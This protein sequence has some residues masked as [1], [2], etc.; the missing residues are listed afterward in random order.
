MFCPWPALAGLSPVRKYNDEPSSGIQH[1]RR[2]C[3]GRQE[4]KH[5][6]GTTRLSS[7]VVA[8]LQNL[9]HHLDLLSQV[10]PP[11]PHLQ[12]D[13]DTVET[14]RWENNLLLSGIFYS[15]ICILIYRTAL[16]F[17]PILSSSAAPSVSSPSLSP[18][19]VVLTI[20]LQFSSL[21]KASN[22]VN[23]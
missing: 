22:R 7:G 12:V 23:R 19:S 17:W 3:H 5:R 4:E 10:R 11:V 2:S 14:S 1:D 16:C 18:A 9:Y 21:S 20:P 6:H 15:T 13:Q 8:V